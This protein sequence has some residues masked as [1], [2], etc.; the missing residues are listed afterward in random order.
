[1]DVDDLLAEADLP[2]VPVGIDQALA[3]TT[4]RGRARHRRR[5][6]VLGAS[7]VLLVGGLTA[8]GLSLSGGDAD[9]Q[10]SAG[11]TTSTVSTVST[12]STPPQ[13]SEPGDPAVWTTDQ[14]HPPS[15]DAT[16]FTALV[17]RVGCG[18]GTGE[19]LRP[20]VVV[21][22][23]EVVVTFRVAAFPDDI[24]CPSNDQVPYEVDL[25]EPLGE[26]RLV[27]GSC[28]P[29][30]DAEVT[31]FCTG[32]GV[33]WQPGLPDSQSLGVAGQ[34]LMVGGPLD[35]EPTPVP[36][37][38]TAEN[39]AGDVVGWAVADSD[40]RFALRLPSGTY[41]LTGQSRDYDATD[42]TCAAERELVVPDDQLT[43]IPVLCQR[44]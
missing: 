17:M 41:R 42:G 18:Q 31:Y 30:S 2:W 23:T 3:S 10:V 15:S 28:R 22:D 26:R 11:S 12:V 24:L 40:G 21:G 44:R 27:D 9:R 7:A 43:D 14:A 32:D 39:R 20:A 16:K 36:G 35:A 34:L 8:A 38:V 19:V 4:R 5:T 1:M 37:R 13:G 29:G 25:G 6:A 33:R